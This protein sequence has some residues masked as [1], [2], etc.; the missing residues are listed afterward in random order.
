MIFFFTLHVNFMFTQIKS[1]SKLI[2]VKY[3]IF[4]ILMQLM[5]DIMSHVTGCR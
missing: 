2:E 3:Y 5:I 4:R 1:Q